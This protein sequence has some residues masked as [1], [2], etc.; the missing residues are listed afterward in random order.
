MTDSRTSDSEKF[1][2]AVYTEQTVVVEAADE[3][4]AREKAVDIADKEKG[5]MFTEVPERVN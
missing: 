3:T 2:V 1:R 4:E 5:E